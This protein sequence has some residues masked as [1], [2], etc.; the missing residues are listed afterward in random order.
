MFS[1]N[2]VIEV[3]SF[4]N[5]LNLAGISI[6]VIIF[7]TISTSIIQIIIVI[8]INFYHCNQYCVR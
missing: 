1:Y 7:V 6:F 2:C 8:I 5:T 3:Y 4:Y